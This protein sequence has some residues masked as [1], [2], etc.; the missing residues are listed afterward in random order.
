[1]WNLKKNTNEIIYEM[2]K[3]STDIENKLIVYQGETYGG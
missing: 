3:D 1:M 2:E